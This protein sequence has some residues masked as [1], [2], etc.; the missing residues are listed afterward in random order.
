MNIT[1]YNLTKP[2]RLTP[3]KLLLIFITT[4]HL[5]CVISVVSSHLPLLLQLGILLAV[6]I[7]CLFSIYQWR[8]WPILTFHVEAGDW[9]LSSGDSKSPRYRILRCSYWHPCLL[10]LQVKDQSNKKS[11]VPL[12]IDSC[13]RSEFKRLQLITATWLDKSQ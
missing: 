2:L 12:P 4:G 8:L 9:V 10:V 13:K 7:H 1:D 6:T 3:S 11:Y 5:L